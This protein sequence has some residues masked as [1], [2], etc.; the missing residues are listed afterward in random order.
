MKMITKRGIFLWILCALFIAGIGFLTFSLVTESS[1]WVMKTYNRHVYSDGQLIAAG[2]IRD[3]NGVVLSESKDGKR[4]YSE[5]KETRLSTLH[6][7]GDTRGFISTGVQTQ[8]ESQLVG[9]NV[10]D[11]VYNIKKNAGGNDLNLT[12]DSEIN[13]VALDALGDYKGTI[14]VVN[15]KTGDIICMVSTPTYDVNDVPSNINTSEKYEGVYINRFLTGLYTPGSTFK[16]V[17]AISALQNIGSDIY[18]RTWRCDRVYDVDGIEEDNIICNAR[19]GTTDFENAFAKV[20][21]SHSA[22]SLL[23]SVRKNWHKPWIPLA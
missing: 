6:V 3:K 1:D 11:G 23:N 10:V 9:Y 5:D 17:T 8:F 19:H 16:V 22:R 14:G 12:I 21:I 15:Y 7:V 13:K 2:E 18:N 4:V 20:V